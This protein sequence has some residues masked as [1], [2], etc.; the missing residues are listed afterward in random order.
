[1]EL[2]N[3][4]NDLIGILQFAEKLIDHLIGR[5]PESERQLFTEAWVEEVRPK[6]K[7]VIEDVKKITMQSADF[8][9]SKLSDHGLTGKSLELKKA[10]LTSLAQQGFLGRLLRLL[11]SLLDSLGEVFPATKPVKELKDCLEDI[12]AGTKPDPYLITLFNQGGWVP[13]P[14]C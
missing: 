1:M 4:K 12:F 3:D 5:L 8:P 2:E 13:R 6:L 14:S 7:A 9:A 10:R 11:D